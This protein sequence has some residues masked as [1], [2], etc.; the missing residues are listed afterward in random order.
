MRRGAVL[1]AACGL[2]LL[3]VALAP[4]TDFGRVYGAAPACVDLKYVP[5]G[6]L[7]PPAACNTANCTPLS[8]GGF[9]CAAAAISQTVP[10]KNFVSTC[11][12][13]KSG[14][15]AC[16]NGPF[17]LVNCGTRDSCSGCA[18]D[19]TGTQKCQPAGRP[20]QNNASRD[21]VK[22]GS[23]TTPSG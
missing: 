9:V 8:G 12:A 3:A 2:A 20:I 15:A 16:D 23:C 21:G 13:A 10:S 1:S 17:P 14:A 4:G 11:T 22:G 18:P 19:A 6:T 5:C 7:N